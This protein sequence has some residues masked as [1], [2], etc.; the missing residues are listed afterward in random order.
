MRIL[1]TGARG[2]AGRHLTRRLREAGHDVAATDAPPL[3]GDPG[4]SCLPCDLRD[5]GAVDRLVSQTAPEACVHLGGIAFVPLGWT[6]PELVFSVNLIG[7]VYLLEAFRKQAPAARLLVVASA[8][9]YGRDAAGAE[10]DEDAPARP[11]NLYALSKLAADQTALLYAR[12]YSMPVMTAR[13]GNHIGPG[14]SPQFVTASFAAQLARMAMGRQAPILKTGN[15]DAIR[16]FTDVRDV[17]R[18]Y[19][20]LLECGVPGEAYNISSGRFVAIRAMLD[21]LCTVSGIRPRIETD[22]ALFRPA[23]PPPPVNSG[24]LRKHTGWSPE[25]QLETTLRDLYAVSLAQAR[26]AGPP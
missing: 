18:A 24:K 1:V 19:Q 2:F 12:R 16:D 21:L 6:D 7:T 11:D 17:A 9:I 13:P 8:E 5:A 26:E 14:Q 25:I 22:P 15:L 20:L 23:D 4:D 3:S 10:I